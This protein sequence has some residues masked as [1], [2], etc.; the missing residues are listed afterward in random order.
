MHRDIDGKLQCF[1]GSDSFRSLLVLEGNGQVIYGGQILDFNKG[2]S[3]FVPA[4]TENYT[5]A[6]N[7][8]VLIT[9]AGEPEPSALKNMI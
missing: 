6:G 4:G 7:C 1:A 9:L 2:D 8:E 5:I 3:I